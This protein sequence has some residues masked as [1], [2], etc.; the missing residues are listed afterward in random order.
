MYEVIIEQSVAKQL[1]KL[2]AHDYHKI[3]TGV[4]EL[5]VNPRPHGYLKLKGREGYP[6]R[7]E[8]YRVIYEI[9]DTKFLVLIITVAHH[10]NVYE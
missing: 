1:E 5:G 6:I 10:K 2:P 7:V 4:E 9:S 3:K 8:N